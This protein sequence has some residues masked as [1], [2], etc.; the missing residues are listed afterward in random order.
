[1]ST[2][3]TLD[4]NKAMTGLTVVRIVEGRIAESRV[5]K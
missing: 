3:Y 4:R 5:E 2:N 1:M